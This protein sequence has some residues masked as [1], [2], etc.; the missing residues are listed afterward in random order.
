MALQPQMIT[1]LAQQMMTNPGLVSIRDYS[2]TYP[3]RIMPSTYL[4]PFLFFELEDRKQK[5]IKM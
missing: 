1:P 5:H 3:L 4:L 2:F